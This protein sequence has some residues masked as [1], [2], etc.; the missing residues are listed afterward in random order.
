ML[1]EG[2]P[3]GALAELSALLRHVIASKGT[4]NSELARRTSYRRQQIAEAVNGHNV[5]SEGLA[6][7]LDEALDADGQVIAL[8]DQADRERKARR[9]NLLLPRTEA[10]QDVETADLRL[11]PALGRRVDAAGLALPIPQVA[12]DRAAASDPDPVTAT[13]GAEMTARKASEHATDAAGCSL[14]DLTIDQLDDDLRHLAAQY[15]AITLPNAYQQAQALLD[16]AQRSLERTKAPRQLSRLYLL[17]GEAAA[18]CGS[19]CFDLSLLRPAAQ[20]AR[21]AALYG[22]TIEFGP[23]QAFAHGTLAYIAYWQRR[24][25]EGVRHALAA[26]EAPGVGT[27]GRRRIAAIAGRAW[28]HLGETSQARAAMAEAEALTDSSEHDDLHDID[29][30]FGMTIERMLM[31]NAA[32]ALLLGDAEAACTYAQAALDQYSALPAE[33]RPPMFVAQAQADLANARLACGDADGAAAALDA[34]L[35]LPVS[36]RG[37]GVI[38]R[39][40]SIRLRLVTPAFAQAQALRGYGDAIEDWAAMVPAQADLIRPVAPM[41]ES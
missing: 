3:N 33:Q 2:E 9:L 7:K 6:K 4:N 18:L 31:S 1:A 28:A 36:W 41:T 25:A 38:Q 20:F 34:V 23:L 24:P 39:V 11:M 10:A 26:A 8:R 35:T 21:T 13:G 37:T 30:E 29:G 12:G 16:V 5:P 40:N 22:Q 17:A 32:T 27:V 19:A 14:P 15:G